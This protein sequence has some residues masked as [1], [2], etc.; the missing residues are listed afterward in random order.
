MAKVLS[1][2]SG[3]TAASGAISTNPAFATNMSRPPL[4]CLHLPEQTIEIF[5]LSD[6]A[7]NRRD[8]PADG[9]FG[10]VEFSLASAGDEDISTF[11]D[12]GLGSGQSDP[13]AA[14]GYD[15]DFPFELP[16]EPLLLSCNPT[17]SEFGGWRT[18]KQ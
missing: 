14:A 17:G 2:C 16:H 13:T 5:E 15:G 3:V 1:K 11:L 10:L 9:R 6:V 7:L 4:F 12:E 8:V 18:E